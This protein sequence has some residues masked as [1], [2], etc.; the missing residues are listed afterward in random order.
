MNSSQHK[1]DFKATQAEFTSY[2]RN[3]DTQPCPEG[4][5]PERMQMYRELCFNNVESFLSSNFPVLRKITS[6]S[7]WQQLAQDFFANHPST[8]PYFSEI[9][10]EFIV[11]LQQERVAG[12]NDYPFMLE[13]AHYEWVEMALSIA[14]ED[15]VEP[16]INQISDLT[17]TLS[18]SPLAWV[19]AYQFPVHKISPDY[20]PLQAPEHPSYLAVY[21]NQEDQ[22]NFIE[23]AQMSYFL[24]HT[25]QEQQAI[26]IA[27][28]L[29]QILPDDS[30]ESLENSAIEAIQQFVDKQVIL[31]D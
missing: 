17:Q 14:Q 28:C 8:T 15:I 6:D 4:I 13:L 29:S 5:K 19:L 7:Q 18:I 26:S 30:A 2:I 9:P 12:A 22:V 21:R 27:D 3:P 10:E 1:V 24:L 11:Y 31:I 25:L 23:L 20:L 16:K